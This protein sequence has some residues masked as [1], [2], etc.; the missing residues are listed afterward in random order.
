MIKYGI[1]NSAQ[2]EELEEYATPEVVDA[3]NACMNIE[4]VQ[5]IREAGYA[6]VGDNAQRPTWQ[7]FSILERIVLALISSI[8]TQEDKLQKEERVF[9][10]FE[11][12]ADMLLS[13]M[14]RALVVL[15]QNNI[16]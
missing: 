8:K 3:L 16:K 1:S 10:E 6:Y 5:S 9:G 12:L 13:P 7:E 15:D 14:A 4:A 2:S 11:L